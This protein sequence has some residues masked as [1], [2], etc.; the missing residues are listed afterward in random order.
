MNSKRLFR[1]AGT[2]LLAGGLLAGSI[3]WAAA[4]EDPTG[5]RNGS[6]T[7]GPGHDGGGDS[8]AAHG[9]G[10]AKQRDHDD[11]AHQ[12]AVAEALDLTVE[13]LQAELEDG[14]TVPQIGEEQGVDLADLHEAI[15]S[16]HDTNGG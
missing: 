3:G 16:Q 2:T 1:L 10:H 8:T 14:K 5:G 6:T 13:E 4:Q 15:M 7:H 12:A 11:P 9:P